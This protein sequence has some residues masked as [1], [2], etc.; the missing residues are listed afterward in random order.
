MLDKNLYKAA[1]LMYEAYNLTKDSSQIADIVKVSMLEIL[2]H[3]VNVNIENNDLTEN[4]E[5]ENEIN[6]LVNELKAK[7]NIDNI[8]ENFRNELQKE[9]DNISQ[10]TRSLSSE[11]EEEVSKIME[12]L[13]LELGD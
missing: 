1:I 7:G 9:W 4:I 3:F 10:N 13:Q 5:I 8:D 2:T 11:T 6:D 12:E